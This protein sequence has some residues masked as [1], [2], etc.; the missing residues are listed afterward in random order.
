MGWVS[1]IEAS[2]GV[3]DFIGTEIPRRGEAEAEAYLSVS[4]FIE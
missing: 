3:E 4:V 2:Y 1:D